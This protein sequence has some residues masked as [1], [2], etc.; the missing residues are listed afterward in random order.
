MHYQQSQ[1]RQKIERKRARRPWR[2]FEWRNHTEYTVRRA[3]SGR[4]EVFQCWADGWKSAAKEW[5]SGGGLAEDKTALVYVTAICRRAT[6][7]LKIT[8][9]LPLRGSR[10]RPLYFVTV[11]SDAELTALEVYTI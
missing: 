10:K 1:R 5:A 4:T 9:T 6:R 2:A 3:F 11:P 8:E 7:L